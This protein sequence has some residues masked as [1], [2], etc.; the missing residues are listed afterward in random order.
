MQNREIVQR[1]CNPYTGLR[2]R[3]PASTTISGAGYR[4]F[5]LMALGGRLADLT[6]AASI[7]L[8]NFHFTQSRVDHGSM[9]RGGLRNAHAVAP[10]DATAMARLHTMAT[11]C[12][13][14]A[15]AMRNAAAIGVHK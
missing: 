9:D 14:F 15:N 11:A 7:A 1:S 12:R 2:L 13:E 10:V 8:A 6:E 4:L 5:S 3:F